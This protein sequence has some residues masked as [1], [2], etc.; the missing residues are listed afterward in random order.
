MSS[1]YTDS[2]NPTIGTS[3]SSPLVAATAA[4]MFSV[5]PAI[6]PVA[7]KAALQSTARPFPTSGLKGVAAC[8]APGGVDQLECYCTTS[9]CGAGMLDAG[10]AVAAVAVVTANIA[11]VSSAV[12]VGDAVA[13]NGSQSRASGT[14]SITTYLWAVSSGSATF[15]SATNASSATLVASTAGTVVVSLTVTDSA[16]RQASTSTTLTVSTTP[17]TPV[18]PA[19]SSGGGG[20]GGGALNLEWLL[21]LVASTLALHLASRRQRR[22]ARLR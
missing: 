7:L 17:S 16:G 20:G 19:P 10:A 6:T 1:T 11:V 4:L 15:T 5:Q 8:A 18:T 2:F 22:A 13:L 3:F 9:T 12:V 21:T 14:A